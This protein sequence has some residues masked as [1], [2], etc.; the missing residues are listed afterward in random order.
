MAHK[1]DIN[2]TEVFREKLIDFVTEED[3]ILAMLQW[4][5]QQMIHLEAEA[6]VGAEKH[7]H[8]KERLTHFSGTRVRRLDTRVGTIY[9]LIPKLRKGGYVPFF[10]T[11]Q[12]RSEQALMLLIREAFVNGVSTRK[13][14]RLAQKMG[15]ENISAS[16]VSEINKGLDKQVEEF[17]SRPLEADY[18]FLFI[19][20]TYEKVRVDNR[21]MSIAL[22][23][24]MGINRD[25]Q[26]EILAIEPMLE[27]SEETWREFF[28]K[29]KYRGI[30]RIELCVS[31]AHAGIQAAVRKEWIGTSWQRCK[32]H[33]IRNILSKI[34]HSA[35]EQ[36]AAAVKQIWTQP[37]KTSALKTAR[38]IIAEYGKRFPEAIH[39]LEE[40]L[41]DSLQFYAFEGIDSRKISSINSLE[42]T[43]K[44]T[45]RRNR[46][47][48]VFP[49]TRS[50]LRLTTCYLMEY[51]EDWMTETG[52]I[53]RDKIQAMYEKREN[54][55]DAALIN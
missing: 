17:R 26:R 50:Y 18:P 42:R 44:E 39:C 28:K 54:I 35:K 8:S 51:S 15:I 38:G 40:G 41:E 47:V 33:F 6:K 53:S 48:G 31:D 34:P 55:N 16:Q 20:A 14:E 32:V 7:K 5:A 9:L 22:M 37:D 24:A 23:I 21:V 2:Y 45:R 19:D 12:K 49:N 36:V 27:E 46:V 30:K 10:I 1:S 4:T 3:P 43:N 25:G 52:Y 13:I 11:E 29:L